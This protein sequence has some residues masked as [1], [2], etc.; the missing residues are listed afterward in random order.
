MTKKEELIQF[1]QETPEDKMV[2]L[3]QYLRGTVDTVFHELGMTKEDAVRFIHENFDDSV[4]S[5][6]NGQIIVVKGWVYE[7]KPLEEVE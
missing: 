3:M 6:R 7:S 5:E 1:I 4:R 2:V